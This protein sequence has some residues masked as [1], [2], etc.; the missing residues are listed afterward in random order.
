[1]FLGCAAALH[2]P[3]SG[4]GWIRDTYSSGAI[5][6]Q[7]LLQ[8]GQS[9][10]DLTLT[11]LSIVFD[12]GTDSGEGFVYLDNIQVNDHTWTYAGDNGN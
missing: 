1:V 10:S 2:T 4:T 3:G 11:G 12:E 8:T 5:A 6:L 7:V 9:L